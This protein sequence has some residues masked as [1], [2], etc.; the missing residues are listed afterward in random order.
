ML[1]ATVILDRQHRI[2]ARGMGAIDWDAPAI[3]KQLTKLIN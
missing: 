1:P 3:D 2:V